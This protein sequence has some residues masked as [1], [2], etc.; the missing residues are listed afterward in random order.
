MISRKLFRV[1]AFT[2]FQLL[3]VSMIPCMVVAQ[4]NKPLPLLIITDPKTNLSRTVGEAHPL[5]HISIVG[6][7]GLS[8]QIKDGNDKLYVNPAV[9]PVVHFIVGGAIGKHTVS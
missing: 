7:K 2:A 3:I 6:A 4:N 5:D 9:K 8:I 1:S